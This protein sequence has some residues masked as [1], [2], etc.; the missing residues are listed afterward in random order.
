MSWTWIDTAVYRL[1]MDH[2]PVCLEE[3]LAAV[4][5]DPVATAKIREAWRD[6]EHWVAFLE[7][8]GTQVRISYDENAGRF[9]VHAAQ[10]V[11]H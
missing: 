10:A 6:I 7:E 8:R 4:A 11:R 3:L 1:A 5:D 9:V 2:S